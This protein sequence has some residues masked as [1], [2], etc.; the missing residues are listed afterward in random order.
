MVRI[1]AAEM[2]LQKL[3]AKRLDLIDMARAGKPAIDLADMAFRRAGADL[4]S[5]KSAHRGARR[6]FGGEKIDAILTA[7]GRVAP[8]RL[9]HLLAH[10]A[11]IG[12]SVENGT[13]G[14]QSVG[15]MHFCAIAAICAMHRGSPSSSRHSTPI[16]VA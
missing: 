13:R 7:P 14:G 9:L 15:I 2:L 1:V 11:R 8:N 16:H 4:G 5:E 10:L 3:D 6:S 12:A